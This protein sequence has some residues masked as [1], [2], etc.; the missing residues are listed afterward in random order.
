MSHLGR[1]P[2]GERDAAR[3]EMSQSDWDR[4]CRKLGRPLLVCSLV[5]LLSL[6]SRVAKAQAKHAL[7]GIDKPERIGR[8]VALGR[9]GRGGM[10]TVF[11][12]Y[13][14]KLERAVALKFL[15]APASDEKGRDVAREAI[16]QGRL[17]HPNVVTVFEVDECEGE[18]FIVM[19][20]VRGPTL[21]QWLGARPRTW[22]AV[23]TVFIQAG[24]GLAAAH[25][26]GL[27]H[28]DFKPENV[29]I[30]ARDVPK[31]AD[32]GLAQWLEQPLQSPLEPAGTPEYM[33]PEQHKGE[34]VDP[35]SDQYSFCTA[36]S[37]ALAPLRAPKRVQAVLRRGMCKEPEHRWPDLDTLL[38]AL[39]R[40]IRS[41]AARWASFATVV[42]M[43][44]G[45]AWATA[46]PP[47][48]NC[49][50]V[51]ALK[52]TW[53][54]AR[55]AAIEAG[56]SRFVSGAETSTARL[57]VERAE[58]YAVRWRRSYVRSCEMELL[59]GAADQRAGCLESQLLTFDTFLGALE[60][61]PA[62]TLA[63]Q[64][65]RSVL[66]LRSPEDCF[67]EI[68]TELASTPEVEELLARAQGEL[69]ALNFEAGLQLSNQALALAEQTRD[70]FGTGRAWYWVAKSRR[71]NY[72]VEQALSAY[73]SAYWAAYEN[74][75]ELTQ[76]HASAQLTVLEAHHRRNTQR[77]EMWRQLA[78]GLGVRSQFPP[79]TRELILISTAVALA[80]A[81]RNEEAEVALAQ[82][83]ESVSA[84]AGE[85]SPFYADLL[86]QQAAVKARSHKFAEAEA[87]GRRGAELVDK[88][89]GAGSVAAAQHWINLTHYLTGNGKDD[90]V[91]AILEPIIER[92]T[93]VYGRDHELTTHARINASGTYYDQGNYQRALSLALG[94]PETLRTQYNA[95]HPF[96]GYALQAIAG[97]Q[98][99]MG[100]ADAALSTIEQ[101]LPVADAVE[102]TEPLLAASIV[103]HQAHALHV[104][105]RDALAQAAF[106]RQLRLLAT[107]G[108]PAVVATAKVYYAAS[109]SRTGDEKQAK[110][111]LGEVV[112]LERGAGFDE[113][114]R[115]IVEQAKRALHGPP[116]GG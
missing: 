11:E 64:A 85:L 52:R 46:R 81:G 22:Q 45:V 24:R 36:L 4:L 54:D 114:L 60:N 88:Q 68:E 38:A 104:L 31:V 98:L 49:E 105:H 83:L 15:N 9:L 67:L 76:A 56:L 18:T 32:F 77:S 55:A 100:Q 69:M 62:A 78:S 8:F 30:A 82:A 71:L 91:L 86:M 111:L 25:A 115:T 5:D 93:K 61:D 89:F 37:E 110:E 74:G 26:Q 21:L 99:E 29:L 102:L 94:A 101:A 53:N 16:A 7:L 41:G 92:L 19:E 63:L 28:R 73:E 6:G 97:P 34:R 20:L 12:A 51:P 40:S 112:L 75:D 59:S 66:A 13:D 44:G 35:R 43:A 47:S 10:G 58:D 87:L 107:H 108:E 79:H 57:V 113:G 3:T 116:A 90:Q 65:P 2:R 109:L 48:A 96:V 103:A 80:S 70:S 95:T 72:Q 33:A 42:C 50:Q 14:P 23:L 84:H 17:T 27:V 106:V 1:A 39:Q